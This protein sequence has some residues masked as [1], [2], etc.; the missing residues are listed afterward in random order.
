MN[1]DLLN[2]F[3][4]RG[5]FI[6]DLD[7]VCAAQAIESRSEKVSLLQKLLYND[8]IGLY[9]DS[10]LL[11]SGSSDARSNNSSKELNHEF[12]NCNHGIGYWSDGWLAS[13]ENETEIQVAKDGVWF[14]AVHEKVR[15]LDAEKKKCQVFLPKECFYL[16]PGF[17][18]AFG[19]S[20][21]S[22][23]QKGELTRL[24]FNTTKESAKNII[25][26]ITK[27]LNDNNIPFQ[28]KAVN[29]DRYFE[30][31]DSTV[32]Y[33]GIGDLVEH[34]GVFVSLLKEAK[35][36]VANDNIKYAK[37]LCAGI[38]FAEDPSEHSSFGEHVCNSIAKILVNNKVGTMSQ[39][40]SKL[41]NEKIDIKCPFI[42]S[43]DKSDFLFFSESL[44]KA[45]NK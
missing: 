30:R 11:E 36:F 10:V 15:F 33:I 31:K 2:T 17:Y 20:L 32:L 21:G 44:E 35:E 25:T 8:Y 34:I 9:R 37:A 43:N 14:N 3:H 24:Y 28:L 38:S 18:V 12:S 19:N 13:N 7:K 4:R 6:L 42:F 27:R 26:L 1:L 39:Y 23:K 40:A 29:I 5:K 41:A 22:V 16:S 45:L